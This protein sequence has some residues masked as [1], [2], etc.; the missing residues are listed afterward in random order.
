MREWLTQWL[1][2]TPPRPEPIR[3]GAVAFEF[4]SNTLQLGKQSVHLELKQSLVLLKLLAD[5]PRIVTKDQL[6][7]FGWSGV[8]TGDDVLA[9]AISHL[10]KALGDSARSPEFI[11]TV[12][13]Q[14]YQWVAPIRP[15][16]Q[17]LARQKARGETPEPTTS[18]RRWWAAAALIAM[19]ATGALGWHL[20]R[21]PLAD[22]K[23]LLQS[24]DPTQWPIALAHYEAAYNAGDHSVDTLLGIVDSQ[25][26]ILNQ[27]PRHLYQAREELRAWL[28]RALAIAPEQAGIHAR[29]A[30]L[31]FLVEWNPHA[32]YDHYRKAIDLAPE[33]ADYHLLL[34]HLQ[35]ALGEFDAATASLERSRALNPSNFALEM[36]A[37]IYNM[38]R[39]YEQAQLELD[40]LVVTRPNTL[41]YHVSAQSVF[42]NSGDYDRSFQ[43]LTKTLELT[44]YEPAELTQASDIF[45]QDGLAGVYRWLLVDREETRN[46]GQYR[47]PLA[48]ARYSIRFGDLET[49]L[50]Y[51]Q[52]AAE[53]RQFELLWI[54]VD[55]KYD[56]IR[57]DPRFEALVD[58]FG[59]SARQF[60]HSD[61]PIQRP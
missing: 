26:R 24:E 29:L 5:A 52:A 18:P 36:A 25:W 27:Q 46:I 60:A 40:R 42:E 44:G 45:R 12:A 28:D 34:S 58:S 38:Q 4:D 6:L 61:T 56:P 14:G 54:N 41:N 50:V 37:W 32:A 51:L 16:A 19:L 20:Q 13:G 3:F 10:R 33:N 17:N 31:E 53:E 22:A 8:A 21:D 57:G 9:V 15:R 39:N 30:R 47:P 55:P 43:H 35:L 59:L 23:H 49:A 2:G 1:S 7:D 48:Y 11:K